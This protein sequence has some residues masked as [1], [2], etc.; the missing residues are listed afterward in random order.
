MRIMRATFDSVH[1]S[2]E[3]TDCGTIRTIGPIGNTGE[4]TASQAPDKAWNASV[5]HASAERRTGGAG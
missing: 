2:G 1:G 3:P 4:P 5:R